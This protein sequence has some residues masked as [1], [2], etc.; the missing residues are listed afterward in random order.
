MLP[1]SVRFEG[2]A[3]ITLKLSTKH[4]MYPAEVVCATRNA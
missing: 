1:I 4:S 3:D 2:K